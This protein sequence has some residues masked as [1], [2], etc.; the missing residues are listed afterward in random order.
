MKE[1]YMN[2]FKFN[3]DYYTFEFGNITIIDP[4]TAKGEI[5]G[6]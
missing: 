5:P 1:F 4:F 3:N 6:Y 2:T